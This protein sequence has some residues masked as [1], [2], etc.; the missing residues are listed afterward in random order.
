M[1]KTT[2]RRAVLLL[3]A[4]VLGAPRPAAAQLDPLLFLK[5]TQPNVIVAV[6][7]GN[8]MQRDAPSDPANP[9]TTSTYYDP[10]IYTRQGTTQEAEIGVSAANAN[11]QY[12]RKYVGLDYASS[13]SGDKFNV[14]TIAG[15][16]DRDAGFASFEAATRLSIARAAL[17][18]AIKLNQSVARFGLIKMRQGSNLSLASKL[19]AGPV[20]DLDSVNQGVGDLPGVAKWGLSRPTVSSNN[21]ASA[22]SGVLVASDAANAN[23]S[24]LSILTKDARTAGALLPAGNDDASTADTPVKLMLDDARAEAVRLIT[25]DTVCRNTI[26]VLIVGG[27]EGT[28]TAGANPATTASTFLNV[29]SRRVPVYVIAIAPPAAEVAQLQSIATNSGGRYFEITKAMID[30]ALAASSKP[31]LTSAVPTGTAVVPEVVRAVNMAVQDTFRSYGDFNTAPSGSLPYGPSTEFPTGSPIVGT[32]NLESAADITGTA[33]PNTIVNDTAGTKIPQRGN[34][35]L[36]SGFSLPGFDG[37]LRAFRTYKPQVDSSQASGYKFVN[38]ATRLWVAVAPA[39]GSRNIYT[40]LPDGTVTAFTAANASTL[41]TYMNVSASTASSLITY[42]RAQPLGAVVDST[43]AVMDPPSLDPPPDESYPG[44]SSANANRRTIIWVGANDGMLHG[45]DARLGVEVWAYIPFN[46]LPKLKELPYGQSIGSF[47]YFADGSPKVADV[48][49]SAPCTDGASSCWRTYLFFGEGPGGTFYQAFDVTMADMSSSVAPTSDSASAVLSYFSDPSKI[50]FK[51]AFPSFSNFDYTLSY[52][53]SPWGDI[54]STASN[55]MKTVGTTWADPAVGQIESTTG[56]YAIVFGSGFLPYSVQQQANR[57]GI[58]AGTTFYIANVETG[59]LYDSMSAGSDGIAETT[60]NCVTANDCTKIKNALQADPVATGPP[61]SRYITMVY[62]GDL[63]GRVWRFDVGTSSVS[64]LPYVKTKTKLWDGGASHPIF[65]SMATVNVGNT[66]QYIFF[67]TGSD[68]LPSNGVSLQYKLVAVLDN[69]SSG[70]QT[71]SQALTKVDGLAGDEKVT[72][73][74]AV[75]GDIVFFTTTTFNP[76]TPCIL[77]SAKL[78]ALTFLGGPAYDTTGDGRITGSDSTLVTTIANTRATAPFVGD[79]HLVFGTGTDTQILGRPRSVQQR[80]GAGGRP[81]H[82]MARASLAT[83][84]IICPA[85]GGKLKG[86]RLRCLRCG[87]DLARGS[88]SAP[89]EPGAAA[90]RLPHGALLVGALFLTAAILAAALWPRAAAPGGSEP[91]QA[92]VSTKPAAPS[93]TPGPAAAVQ[94]VGGPAF[95]EPGRAGGAAY[96]R[97]DFTG[98]LHDF[99]EAVRKNPDDLQSLNNFGQTLVRLDRAAEA[100]PYFQRAMELN[101]TEWSP[102]F[103]LAHAYEVMNDWPKAVDAYRQAAAVF[104]EDYATRY[105]LGHALHQ[106]GD[107]AA[108]VVEFKKAIELAPGEPSFLVALGL[109]YERLQ[110]PASAVEAYEQYLALASDAPDADRVKARIQALKHPA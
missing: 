6:D 46:L 105:N 72:A 107:D 34:L 37:K 106:T 67:G 82:V 44:F 13:G 75:A 87:A 80:R 109:S 25:A 104:P 30:A 54:K 51:W 81:D 14:N 59:S 77:P 100:V 48:R 42:V 84:A 88:V 17:D 43:P 23:T 76:A 18:Q 26:V 19:N 69:G 70:T 4:A 8:R 103:N 21:G 78:Y 71:F 56:A 9:R 108:A 86:G 99:E 97:G 36:V 15:V 83:R 1:T 40:V 92:A 27:G 53:S 33:L 38:D 32:V 5:A 94:P 10:Y 12:R 3:G 31:G 24:V 22:A 35:L 49:V 89:M 61:N 66:Q 55:T 74:P 45:I 60:D 85:C 90:G 91:A 7:V 110:Q 64:G 63:D 28:T 93:A 41:A 39:A 2:V 102:R 98:A 95:L 50:A 11:T 58:A 79:R 96:M 73:F 29:N 47:N 57:G 101:P 52:S 68:L 65:S 62:V 16:G 20:N